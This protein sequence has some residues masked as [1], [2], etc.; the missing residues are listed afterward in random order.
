[1]ANVSVTYTF[2]N[3]TT[4]DATQVNQNFTDVINGTSDGTKD[5]SISALTCAGNVAFNGNTTI[6]NASGDDLTIT[7]S[8][9]STIAIKTTNSYNIGSVTKG[10]QY[11]YFG[12]S[13]GSNTTRVVG[14][15]VS[16]DVQLILPE[17]SGTIALVGSVTSSKTSAYTATTAD[18]LI[19]CDSSGGAFTVTL[20]TAVGNGGKVLRIKKTTSDFN[21]VTI[22]GNSSETIDGATTTTINTQNEVLVIMSDGSNWQIIDRRIPKIKT[23][24]TPGTNVSTN[25]ATAGFWMRDGADIL[26]DLQISWS[27]SPSAFSTIDLDT[28]SGLTV[29]TGKMNSTTASRE[30]VGDGVYFDPSGGTTR[31]GVIVSYHDTNT[32]RLKYSISTGSFTY[33]TDIS[34]TSPFTTGN[35]VYANVKVRLPI[36]GWN[37]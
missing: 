29:D 5:F 7:A 32:V 20:Y 2:S 28:P 35:G 17:V 34:S 4:A 30:C 37:G 23:A 36:S 11:I 13:S 19:P 26:L 22:D 21:A 25:T 14:S 10:L 33:Y 27:G 6:G 1:M 9:A 31:Y 18:A 15:A 8:L 12:S 16:S 24:Y 3:S